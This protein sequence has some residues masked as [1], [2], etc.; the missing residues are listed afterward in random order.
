MA[1]RSNKSSLDTR[2]QGRVGSSH[3]PSYNVITQTLIRD[4][5]H[6]DRL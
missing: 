5:Y 3:N 2:Y 6:T 4:T 1:G